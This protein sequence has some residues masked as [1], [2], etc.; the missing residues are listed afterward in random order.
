MATMAMSESVPLRPLRD[1]VGGNFMLL[2]IDEK[3][4]CKPLQAR[5]TLFYETRHEDLKG[6][7]PE[8]KGE[9]DTKIARSV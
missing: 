6:F 3:Y 1:Q 5:E 4:V 2:E 7:T 8:Y 9:S